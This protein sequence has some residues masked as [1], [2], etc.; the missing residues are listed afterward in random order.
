[1][2]K[3]TLG[4]LYLRY[5]QYENAISQ[6]EESLKISKKATTLIK[7][8]QAYQEKISGSK[9]KLGSNNPA[10]EAKLKK[11]IQQD[12][13]KGYDRAI[14]AVQLSQNIQV[15]IISRLNILKAYHIKLS[16]KQYIQYKFEVIDL[17]NLLE[18]SSFKASSLIT[19]GKI[20][21]NSESLKLL[22][23]AER[24]SQR[25]GD[26]HN[27]SLALENLGRIYFSLSDIDLAKENTEKA[28]L[29]AQEIASPQMLFHQ[30]R[31]LGE[32]E[33]ALGNTKETLRAYS[34]ALFNLRSPRSEFGIG[35]NFL[36]Y[37]QEDAQIFLRKYITLLL[38]ENR[39]AEAIE[40][41]STFKLSEFQ[42]YFDDPCLEASD[43]SYR[44]PI[45][46][47]KE[48]GI[49]YSFITENKTY[50]LVR[51]PG[52]EIIVREIEI[53]QKQLEKQ[54]IEH[55]INL[56]SYYK[57]GYLDTIKSVYNLLIKPIE[58]DLESSKIK[59]I[60]FIHDGILRNIPMESLMSKDNSYL[61]EKYTI[62]SNSGLNRPIR[63]IKNRSRKA[64]V[65]GSSKFILNFEP[66]PFAQKEI[67][68]LVEIL[69]NSVALLNENFTVENVQKRLKNGNYVLI[70]M[71]THG[72]FG[73]SAKNSYLVT[74]DRL[75]DL[76][77]LYKLFRSIGKPPYL[78]FLS[79][80]KTA[81]GNQQAPL[82]IS[83]LGIKIGAENVVGTL[84]VVQDRIAESFVKN[85]YFYLSQGKSIAEAKRQA[86]LKLLES[87]PTLWSTFV[88]YE[89]QENF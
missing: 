56:T 8:S 49:V 74:Y 82:G 31:Q 51:L 50:L 55:R 78:L 61:I 18:E 48:R 62:A 63:T 52:G 79:A 60:T 76:D 84:W 32:I 43:I 53:T 41:L 77:R 17:I 59:Q 16:Q 80:C 39:G 68:F 13:N 70:H 47:L 20:L 46:L 7:L 23:Q 71:A 35:N 14:K 40:I 19:L 4:N 83:G 87:P 15:K 89:E 26:R 67:E 3:N 88:N 28:I 2:A 33:S 85:F 75:V 66:L 30:L 25:I 27:Y 54:I 29:I 6:Y 37:L 34:S 9:K 44:E 42:A 21:N 38:E 22:S 72:F 86:Q 65:A 58:K 36:F 81:E 24:I 12:L 11:Q 57:L 69:E 1:L 5:R 73:G 45:S 64:L 10:E